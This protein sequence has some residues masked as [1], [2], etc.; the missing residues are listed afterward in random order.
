VDPKGSTPIITSLHELGHKI[1]WE[2]YEGDNGRYGS[3]RGGE[4]GPDWDPH[5][6]MRKAVERMTAEGWQYAGKRGAW[7]VMRKDGEEV[8][9]NW[10][11]NPLPKSTTSFDDPIDPTAVIPHAPAPSFM[12]AA[13][14]TET[15]RVLSTHPRAK[16]HFGKYLLQ[17]RELFA[18]AFS[19][20]I[21]SRSTDPD[22]QDQLQIDLGRDTPPIGLTVEQWVR[23]S[24]RNWPQQW[25]EEDFAPIAAFFDDLMQELGLKVPN[26]P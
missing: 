22:T 6:E 7:A 24:D 20:Y 21:A 26:A 17:P 18:R 16:E 2:I 15:W 8:R 1:D 11:G 3:E 5:K 23:E 9:L 13:K 10:A 19:Q 12:G 14:E 4:M 25:P